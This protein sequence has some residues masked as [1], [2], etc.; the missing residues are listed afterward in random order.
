MKIYIKMNSEIRL[1]LNSTSTDD[2]L[3]HGRIE[4]DET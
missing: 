2:P 3:N 1:S 4:E